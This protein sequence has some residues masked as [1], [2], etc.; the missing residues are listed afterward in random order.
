MKPY[1]QSELVTLYYG[2]CLDVAEWLTADVLVT[3]P[4]YGQSYKSN[5]DRGARSNWH[6]KIKGDETTELRDQALFKWGVT[7]S[8]LVFGT[9]KTEKP[10][11]TRQVVIWDKTPCGFMG[12]LQIPFGNAHEE[13]YCLGSKGWNGAREAS[14]VKA[15]MLM[16]NDK[17]R[18]DHPTPKPIGLMEKLINK[19]SGVIADPFAGSGSTLLAARNLGR[20]VIG[21]EL[22]EKYC[23]LIANRLSQ[24]AFDFGGI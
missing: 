10:E 15:Q 23:E 4:P 11:N 19:T 8:A 18:P 20:K 21:V 9:W 16:S 7:K 5:M 12:D 24:E 22:E 14:V 13:I 6:E 2:D 3:D 1:Y 17:S